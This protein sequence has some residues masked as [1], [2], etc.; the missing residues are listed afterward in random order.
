VQPNPGSFCWAIKIDI[1][2]SPVGNCSKN[3]KIYTLI[4]TQVC[5]LDYD[6][7]LGELG[8]NKLYQQHKAEF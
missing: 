4:T 3:N 1:L 2:G 5:E 7:V 8:L 6:N